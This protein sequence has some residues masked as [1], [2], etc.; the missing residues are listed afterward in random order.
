MAT[1]EQDAIRQLFGEPGTPVPPVS[2]KDMK[3]L[4]QEFHKTG[5]GTFL[6]MAYVRLLSPDSDCKAVAFRCMQLMMIERLS[7]FA[8]RPF[9]ITEGV[10]RVV[11]EIPLQY[12]EV[13]KPYSPSF[14]FDDFF[15]KVRTAEAGP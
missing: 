11:A 1:D 6:G 12:L 3:A 4:W 8:S 15:A 7:Q 10:F 5:R 13:G 14:N 2:V 9:E